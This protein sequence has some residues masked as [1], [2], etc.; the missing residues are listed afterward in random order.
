LEYS[1]SLKKVH[2]NLPAALHDYL[3]NFNNF[4]IEIDKIIEEL[5]KKSTSG[6]ISPFDFRERYEIA[7]MSKKELL[8]LC[9]NED[10]MNHIKSLLE[11]L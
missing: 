8:S 10:F 9:S 3:E 1:K 4:A 2:P 11:F 6:I 7:E 5:K